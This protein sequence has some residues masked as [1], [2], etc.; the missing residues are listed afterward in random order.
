MVASSFKYPEPSLDSI[1][2]ILE[3]DSETDEKPSETE[4]KLPESDSQPSSVYF[5][6]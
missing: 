1:L 5:R 3:T 4:A 2:E 6:V